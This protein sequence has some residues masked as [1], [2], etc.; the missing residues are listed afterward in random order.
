MDD[1]INIIPK[2]LV[3][4]LEKHS[5]KRMECDPAIKGKVEIDWFTTF[6]SEELCISTFKIDTSEYYLNYDEPGDDPELIYEITGIDLIKGCEG[7]DPEG[8]L[9][10]FPQFSEFG[11]WDCDHMIITMYPK[12]SW[13]T[14]SANLFDYVNGQ[15]YPDRVNHY[16]LRPWAD[17]RCRDIKPLPR[18]KD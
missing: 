7:Y 17:D 9:I 2:G 6:S 5:K 8:I 10:Y 1:I 18:G 4:F 11:S 3:E 15:W 13:E 16:L 14:I 12:A